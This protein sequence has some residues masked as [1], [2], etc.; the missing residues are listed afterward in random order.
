LALVYFVFVLYGN[1][2]ESENTDEPFADLEEED[3]KETILIGP[4]IKPT[5]EPTVEPTFVEP[6]IRDIEP[7]IEVEPSL[8]EEEEENETEGFNQNQYQNLIEDLDETSGL[9]A[10]F[11]RQ[12]IDKNQ[13]F[14]TLCI[15]DGYILH[16]L[17]LFQM[18][19]RH[20]SKKSFGVLVQDVSEEGKKLF[21][22]F[23][24][25][26][27]QIDPLELNPIFAPGSQERDLKLFMKLRVWE[28]E[29][30][31]KVVLLDSDVYIRANMDDIFEYSE[32]SA[33]PMI[34]S[35]EQIA[36]FKH[37]PN[38]FQ[39]PKYK[40]ATKED[41]IVGKFGA[42]SGIS[43]LTPSKETFNEM[44]KILSV[45]KSRFCCPSQEFIYHFFMDKGK[46]TPLPFEYQYRSRTFLNK[47][48]R[49]TLDKTFRMY[50]FVE[51]T[52][53]WT[54]DNP[55]T[56]ANKFIQAWLGYRAEVEKILENLGVDLELWKSRTSTT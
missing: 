37:T 23:N 32:Y 14:I 26:V 15:N 2:S 54:V 22:L 6:F 3:N 34:H 52:K 8:E 10:Q 18:L 55:K 42:N 36:F 28:L 44:I 19:A 20:E 49:A 25:Q 16:S 46:F 5:V 31:E 11:N 47:T 35:D 17:V 12:N 56:L 7:E 48:M 27:F 51:R 45:A 1:E 38:F 24:I 13:A 30:F 21:E 43:V 29:E 9:K 50:H 41:K 4:L 39:L 40:K 53:P 33:T